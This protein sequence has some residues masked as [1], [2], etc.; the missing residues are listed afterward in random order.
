VTRIEE[1]EAGMRRIGCTL[2]AIALATGCG[3]KAPAPA[4]TSGTFSALALGLPAAGAAPVIVGHR[5]GAGGKTPEN[6]MA[7][8]RL[9]PTLG[10]AILECDVH[11]SKDGALVV[12]HDDTVDRT[13]DGKGPVHQLTLAQLK[14]LDA[15][16]GERIPTLPELLEF[17]ASRPELKVAVEIKAKRKVCPDVAD[18][19][20]AAI[21]KAGLTSRTI[22]ISFH[23]DAVER[24]EA[25]L[26]DI[27]TGLLFYLRLNPVKTAKK[28]HADMLWSPRHRTT[29]RF[30]QSA[31]AAGFPVYSWTL[32]AARQM[33]DARRIGVNS[34]V[35]NYAD[36]AREVFQYPDPRLGPPASG[37]ASPSFDPQDVEDPDDLATDD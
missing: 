9:G 17:V 15:G 19:V 29:T 20:V 37:D 12:I 23:R 28:I 33:L 11:C 8:F 14:Q 1:Q 26:P 35:T 2:A 18:K 21:G 7:A 3:L 5:G 4:G 13:T 30:V 6:T 31:H 25:L 27:A 22:V 10:A 34:V 16:Q 32:D 36:V 24:T